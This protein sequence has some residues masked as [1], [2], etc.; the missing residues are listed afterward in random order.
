MNRPTDTL[1][2]EPPSHDRILVAVCTYNERENL[3]KL[4][5]DIRRAVPQ[6]DILVVDDRSPDGTGDWAQQ[7]R[8]EAPWL[9]VTIREGKLG[10]GSAIV[11]AMRYAC[12]EGYAYLVN[13]DGDRSHDPASIPALLH[14]METQQADVAIGSRYVEGGAIEGWPWSRRVMS[15]ALNRLARFSLGLEAYDCSGAFR[16]YRIESLRQVDLRQVRCEGYAML[17]EILWLLKGSDAKIVEIP[18]TFV[19]R[20]EGAS[21]LSFSEAVNALAT[22]ARLAIA[23]QRST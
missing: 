14:A 9:R 8:A 19:N 22:L 21:K 5:V 16:C 13:L 12:R 7:Q 2:D 23:R 11:H 3:P 1:A 10:L 4:L 6:A 15:H 20:T 18:I 17:E